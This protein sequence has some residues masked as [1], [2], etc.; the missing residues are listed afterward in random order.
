MINFGIFWSRLNH[1]PCTQISS[2]DYDG[3][4]EPSSPY[5][6]KSEFITE[7]QNESLSYVASNPK[8]AEHLGENGKF[9]IFPE[10][11]PNLYLP[12]RANYLTSLEGKGAFTQKI[13]ATLVVSRRLQALVSTIFGLMLILLYDDLFHLLSSIKEATIE[14]ATIAVVGVVGFIAM[15]KQL[16]P[17]IPLLGWVLAYQASWKEWSKSQSTDAG[18]RVKNRD[19][20][21]VP[22]MNAYRAYLISREMDLELHEA[23]SQ[24]WHI[25]SQTQVKVELPNGKHIVTTLIADGIKGEPKMELAKTVSTHVSE[26]EKWLKEHSFLV[27]DALTCLT[28]DERTSYKTF[29]QMGGRE[30][31]GTKD[32]TVTSES[33]V[34]KYGRFLEKELLKRTNFITSA[35]VKESWRELL[36]NMDLSKR[37]LTSK[38][39][40]RQPVTK[41]LS[42]MLNSPKNVSRCIYAPS[43]RGKTTT[44]LKA[45]IEL[46]ENQNG[47]FLPLVIKARN[48]AIEPSDSGELYLS[49]LTEPGYLRRWERSE[50]RLMIVD[51]VDEN[52]KFKTKLCQMLYKSAD[53]YDADVLITTRPN[54]LPEQIEHHELLNFDNDY[55]LQLIYSS[56]NNPQ[57]RSYLAKVMPSEIRENALTVFG[58]SE[59]LAT[60]YASGQMPNISSNAIAHWLFK[61]ATVETSSVKY[62][63]SSDLNWMSLTVAIGKFA[64]EEALNTPL[65]KRT[66]AQ[67]PGY[68]KARELQLF[69]ENIGIFEPLLEPYCMFHV[70]EEHQS[71]DL[72][73]I[74]S[75]LF[76]DEDDDKLAMFVKA[77]LSHENPYL[78]PLMPLFDQT[79][80]DEH[81]LLKEDILYFG[82]REWLRSNLQVRKRIMRHLDLVC[83]NNG[84]I[85][86]SSMDELHERYLQS[87]LFAGLLTFHCESWSGEEYS[88]WILKHDE[89]WLTLS[90]SFFDNQCRSATTRAMH[91]GEILSTSGLEALDAL[92]SDEVEIPYLMEKEKAHV[93]SILKSMLLPL[94]VPSGWEIDKPDYRPLRVFDEDGDEVEHNTRSFL[95][96]VDTDLVWGYPIKLLPLNPTNSH[97]TTGHLSAS[98]SFL[99][100]LESLFGKYVGDKLSEQIYVYLLLIRI[101]EENTSFGM[102]Y[103]ER[104]YESFRRKYIQLETEAEKC[105]LEKSYHILRRGRY[106]NRM[107]SCFDDDPKRRTLNQDS[108]EGAGKIVADLNKFCVRN[109][110]DSAI[111]HQYQTYYDAK[112]HPPILG[113]DQ[114]LD[115]GNKLVYLRLTKR[116]SKMPFDRELSEDHLS[117]VAIV[118]SS[119]FYSAIPLELMPR[120]SNGVYGWPTFIGRD[121]NSAGTDEAPYA[122]PL[123]FHEMPPLMKKLLL[124]DGGPNNSSFLDFQDNLRRYGVI[125]DIEDVDTLGYSNLRG[126]R[127]VGVYTSQNGP[128][129]RG[130]IWYSVIGNRS[131]NNCYVLPEMGESFDI[132]HDVYLRRGTNRIAWFDFEVDV[133][134]NP[135]NKHL[136]AQPKNIKFLCNSC[137]G[138]ISEKE[139]DNHHICKTCWEKMTHIDAIKCH[140]HQIIKTFPKFITLEPENSR[141][142]WI[143]IRNPSEDDISQRVEAVKNILSFYY[144]NIEN[145]TVECGTPVEL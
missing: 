139:I 83:D 57:L 58:S 112:Q 17:R 48:L 90:K 11:L 100:L 143:D 26:A 110:T 66:A 138:I 70:I 30:D 50:K 21:F 141:C 71:E 130:R 12:T 134:E 142:S 22:W 47:E 43:G 126:K 33:S 28:D 91:F 20:V 25:F 98:E 129:H 103:N 69:D 93:E 15:S 111:L 113:W 95:N 74:F 137:L 79:E 82:M 104:M 36:L 5:T 64:L 61:R 73:A 109:H 107:E 92:S 45:A 124:S 102:A 135:S 114:N 72:V 14:N 133:F 136:V 132:L 40:G 46:L 88:N 80:L 101:T 54:S 4:V 106:D 87:N 42:N 24:L 84:R 44:I 37:N 116:T 119:R 78:P 121:V 81:E 115:I 105:L 39:D 108:L 59:L 76:E 94:I 127:L 89:T 120:A 62:N 3:A 65:M 60:S 145:W 118:Q 128:D 13:I 68:E 27:A 67:T 75:K 144:P 38:N 97:T 77:Y 34:D 49:E 53:Y 85:V 86:V 18:W 96:L 117:Q 35:E 56:S 41:V 2:M 6:K 122:V 8:N 1:I 9:I 23:M 131:G 125:T 63:N 55:Q 99:S 29:H 7:F 10:I 123:L 31:G 16:I 140:L 51:G 32:E 52:T 19:E